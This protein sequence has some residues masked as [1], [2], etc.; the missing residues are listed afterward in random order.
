MNPS[1]EEIAEAVESIPAPDIIILPNNKNIAATAEVSRDLIHSKA[2]TVLPTES[3]QQGVAAL[4]AYSA[5][6]SV[7]DNLDGMRGAVDELRLGGGDV[8]RA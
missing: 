6:A 2:V 4:L 1:A 8:C 3:V 5:T 7:Q